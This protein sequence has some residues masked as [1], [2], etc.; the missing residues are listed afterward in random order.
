MSALLCWSTVSPGCGVKKQ[1]GLRFSAL[2][3]VKTPGALPAHFP[4]GPVSTER[5][6][7]LVNALPAAAGDGQYRL[8]VGDVI[9][10]LLF[11]SDVRESGD[12]RMQ[13]T[14]RPDGKVS[15]FFIGDIQ[16]KG[17][18]PTELRGELQEKLSQYIRSP[19]VAVIVVE[20]SKKRVYVVGEVIEQGV[21]HLKT[22]EGDSLLDA[23]F[24]SKGLTKRADADRAYVI[25][26][27]KIAL[28]DLSE[29]LFRGNPSKNMVLESEDVVY[30]PEALEQRIFVLGRVRK[31]GAFEIS[32]P[33]RLTEAIALAEDFTLGAKRDAVRIIRGGL[34]KGPYAPEIIMADAGEY[35]EGSGMDVYVQRGDIVF[36]PNTPLGDWNDVLIQL[37]PSMNALFSS[38]VITRELGGY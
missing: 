15:Y 38:T 37:L 21:H 31:P 35:R 32:R 1:E 17:L 30:I 14:V 10:I 13:M 7:A 6:N 20:A 24:L 26:R 25:R 12:S 5:S 2:P 18:T 33:I 28:V 3:E 34:P 22:G 11:R 8:A 9:E 23:I 16:A 29:L 27:N 19:E 4:P 36:V